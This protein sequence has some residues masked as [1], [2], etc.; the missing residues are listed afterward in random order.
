MK[1]NLLCVLGATATGKTN[2]AVSLA[3]QLS[4]EIISADSRQ[5]YRN[6]DI[7]TGKDLE[8]YGNISYHLIDT[9]SAG[10]KYN[11]FEYQQDFQ[12]VFKEV[13]TRKKTPILCGGS[14]LYLESVL[15]NYEM[16]AVPP[17][18][19]LRK[20][21]EQK[22]L[23]ELIMQLKE[24]KTLHNTTDTSTKKRTIRALEIATHENANQGKTISRVN[25]QPLIVGIAYSV[26]E[27][28]TRI[29][30][31]LH[32]RLAQGMVAEVQQLLDNGIAAEDLLYYGLEY[33]YITLYLT[34]KLSYEEMVKQ[35]NTAIHRFAKRQMTWFR[36]M[37]RKGFQI[38]WLEGNSTTEEKVN[39]V[40]EL[41]QAVS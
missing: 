33:K 6:M 15:E 25:L 38:Y 21:L 16:Q 8:E 17:N 10:Y 39:T 22:P 34:Q 28:R 20:K 14:G 29:T 4:G 36:R 40:L 41:W 7:G 1:Y 11:V 24:C 9:H 19:T 37:E 26:S 3:Q 32:D 31:R 30:Q 18:L 2:L 12:K 5:I 13:L 35:L 23:S 27:R